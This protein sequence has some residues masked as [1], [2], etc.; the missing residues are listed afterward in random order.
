VEIGKLVCLAN[1][2]EKYGPLLIDA[3]QQ[4]NSAVS[5]AAFVD[6]DG[7]VGKVVIRRV[8]DDLMH[9]R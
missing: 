1:A 5:F 4:R 8:G 7:A 9:A 2:V 6:G 3:V